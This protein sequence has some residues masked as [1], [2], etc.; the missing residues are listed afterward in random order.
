MASNL[1]IKPAR[2]DWRLAQE[3]HSRFAAKVG[4]AHIAKFSALAHLAALLRERPVKSAL[5]FGSGIGTITSLLLERLPP[6]A[7]IVCAERDEWCRQQFERNI[8]A[9][10]RYRVELLPAGR[11]EIE[12]AFDL[13][14]IDGPASH[15]ARYVREGTICFVEGNRKETWSGISAAMADRALA[16]SLT[17]YRGA[18]WKIVWRPSRLGFSLPR[19]ITRT[20]GCWIGVVERAPITAR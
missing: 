16:C 3:I 18:S 12:E 2:E 5:E 1:V 19:K 4:S 10:E 13:V 7:R 14:V 20:I 17:Y 11:P 15:G 6:D 8:P 9:S